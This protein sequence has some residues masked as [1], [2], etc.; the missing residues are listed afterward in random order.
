MSEFTQLIA[1]TLNRY[2]LKESE[3]KVDNYLQSQK[4]VDE[5]SQAMQKDIELKDKNMS[6]KDLL[7]SWDNKSDIIA[8][9]ISWV[10][11]Q[12]A[13]GLFHAGEVDLNQVEEYLNKFEKYKKNKDLF[14]SADINQYTYTDLQ[15]QLNKIPK[16]DISHLGSSARKTI[17]DQG[18]DEIEKVYDDGEWLVVIPLTEAASR[19]WGQGT[20]W[21]TAADSEHNQFKA[22]SSEGSLYIIINQ[23]NPEE[24]YQF[25]F[26][27]GS[28]YSDEDDDIPLDE[29]SNAQNNSVLPEKVIFQTKDKGLIDV[30]Q[31]LLGISNN[32]PLFWE[33]GIVN[34]D[35]L[36][37]DKQIA[38][39]KED[40]SAIKYIKKPS[41][42][43]QLEAVNT[44][45]T[46]IR[47]I[48]N[49]IEEVQ[50]AALRSTSHGH[51]RNPYTTQVAECIKNPSDYVKQ[52][53][54]VIEDVENIKNIKNPSQEIQLVAIDKSKY[55]IKYIDNPCKAAQLRSLYG[56]F[57][58]DTYNYINNPCEEAKELAIIHY[59]FI[60]KDM[61]GQSED[62]QLLALERVN[63]E[64]EG[65]RT[66]AKSDIFKYF[67]NP[68]DKVK[69]EA[70]KYNGL[71]IQYIE[72]PTEEMK[73]LAVKEN[74]NALKYIKN[75]S[76]KIQL[77]AVKTDG[78]AIQ[79]IENPT[80][81]MKL[82][83]VTFQ[84]DKR[85]RYGNLKY[86]ENPSEE[87]QIAALRNPF[88]AMVHLLR[89]IPNA[90]DKVK[91]AAVEYNPAHIESIDNPTEEMQMAAIE[92]DYKLL[93]R[94]NN[95]TEK[96]KQRAEE[97]N[98]AHGG[99]G[100]Y[101]Y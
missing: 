55:A 74:G 85:P 38:T 24:K 31:D 6:P 28:D 57:R 15:T 52:L 60:I 67:K 30:F 82:A 95:P 14:Q 46:A 10:A 19:Y 72:N 34:P 26:A 84:E 96:V 90:S 51:F 65:T 8:K 11:N 64:E 54:S 33:Y 61:E 1:D 2:L 73:L 97:L 9:N 47:Y 78:E 48:E 50:L 39:V 53:I 25:F 66:W 56:S 79:Y 22:Y 18:K 35:N 5:L 63:K 13:K 42:K 89:S 93:T 92:Q 40:G 49:P 29:F 86:I 91:L 41:E 76:E 43:V 59:P 83:A 98:Q 7:M 88:A 21:C 37:E 23:H 62:L 17:R 44:D 27:E 16:D 68:T 3:A 77:E 69:L 81:E 94:I 99:W 70:L 4:K 58:A 71:V 100:Y 12:Y 75:P 101:R 87:V 80:E 36:P 45:G 20:R 32:S